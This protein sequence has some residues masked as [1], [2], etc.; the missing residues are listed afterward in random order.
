PLFNM[1]GEVVGIVNSKVSASGVEGMGYAISSNSA[2]PILKQL[3][4]GSK[5][6]LPWIGTM[7]QTVDPGV[8]FLN[9]LD[10]QQGVLII[11][12]TANSP[13]SG[14]GLQQGDVIISINGKPVLTASQAASILNNSV[15]GQKVTINYQRGTAQSTVTVTVAQN[16]Q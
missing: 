11:D 4:T 12:V 13:A 14:A 9:S 5:L 1:A 3:M 10:I 8:A 7:F 16:P 2:A 6:V 15:I